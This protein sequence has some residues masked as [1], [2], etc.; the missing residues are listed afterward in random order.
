VIEDSEPIPF[1][2]CHCGCGLPAPI[3]KKT[4]RSKG[5]VKGQPVRFINGH[6]PGPSPRPLGEWF[7]EQVDKNGPVRAHCPELGPCWP[8]TGYRD[9]LGYG[10]LRINGRKQLAHHVALE[11]TGFIIPAE[12]L[13]VLHRCDNP[14]CCRPSHLRIGTSQDDADDKVSKER[15][16]R[17]EGN[18][19][20]ELTDALVQEILALHQP[21]VRGRGCKAIA[22]QFGVGKTTINHIVTGRTW[23]H[24]PGC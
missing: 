3:A 5:H 4:N 16:A 1:G 13:Q 17:G 21:G 7:W 6:Q 14:P 24:I 9:E 8:F 18:G 19:N 22:K 11:L 12:F 20:A 23:K 10:R 15:Q 2:Y